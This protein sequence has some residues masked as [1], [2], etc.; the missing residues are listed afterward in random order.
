MKQRCLTL[1]IIILIASIFATTVLRAQ[2]TIGS[3]TP[4]VSGALLELKM[5]GNT[6]KGLCM[7]RVKL[8]EKDKLYPMFTAGYPSSEDAKHIGL[9]VYNTNY[10]GELCPGLYVWDGSEWCRLQEECLYSRISPQELIFYK[11]A[12][13]PKSITIDFYPSSTTYDFIEQSG[14]NIVWLGTGFPT[15]GLSQTTY[16]FQPAPNNSGT[17]R[18]SIVDVQAN[19]PNSMHKTT[20]V[21]ITHLA[22]APN[23]S[24]VPSEN[25]YTP[26]G[27]VGKYLTVASDVEWKVNSV[28]DTYSILSNYATTDRSSGNTTYTFD[29]AANN[30]YVN[31]SADFHITSP[32]FLPKTVTVNQSGT[33]PLLNITTGSSINFGS[34]AG[35]QTVTVETNADFTITG[36]TQYSWIVSSPSVPNYQTGG[37]ARNTVTKNIS[38]TPRTGATGP[39]GIQ[40]SVVTFETRNHPGTTAVSKTVTMSR[41]IPASWS[42]VSITPAAANGLSSYN[43]TT[44]TVRA[45]SN[46][47]WYI[48]SNLGQT[49]T[50][51]SAGPSSTQ[52]LSIVIPGN[53]TAAARNIIIY[54]YVDG[55]RQTI[56]TYNQPV[57]PYCDLGTHWGEKNKTS[58]TSAYNFYSACGAGKWKIPTSALAA[59]L[60]ACVGTDVPYGQTLHGG[61]PDGYSYYGFYTMRSNGSS[62]YYNE[63]C[64]HAAMVVRC[65][66]PKGDL[67]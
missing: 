49:S 3:G 43:N 17:T 44:V 36:D 66:I 48:K 53:F 4:P 38:F 67:P 14:H 11:D 60:A 18:N 64:A 10:A 27:G 21:K 2:V 61:C 42:L 46:Q 15:D 50:T 41:D 28:T 57:S 45:T 56:M 5:D 22:T 63:T 19:F 33:A 23:F 32:D 55:V 30:G 9:W 29:L 40:S 31:R 54:A 13:T 20:P 37:T 58:K 65:V 16:N 34:S 26:A 8:T 52:D 51:I 62:S 1:A 6:T 12:P 25:P 35:A 39:A 24:A 59:K 47:S 7:P